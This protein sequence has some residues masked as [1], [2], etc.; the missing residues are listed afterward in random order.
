MRIAAISV[1]PIFPNYVIGGSQRILADVTA[2]LKNSGHD[3]QIWCTGTDSH[4]GDFEVGGVTV[5]PDL[6]L[7]G[8][9]PATHQVSPVALARTAETLRNAAEWADRVYLHADAVYLRHALEGTEIIRSIHDYVYEEALLSTLTLPAGTTVVPSEYLKQCIEATVAISGKKTIERVVVIPNGV[10]VPETAPIPILPDGI[11][12]RGEQDLILLFPH[13]PIPT[14]GLDEAIRTAVEVQ[15]IEPARNVRLLIPAY[16]SDA[17]FD[18]AAG[19]TDEL[20]ELVN[21]LDAVDIVEFHSWL[22]PTEMPGYYAGGD[23]ALCIGSFVESF[24]LVPVES[25]AN[26]TPA[27]CAR[28]GAFRQFANL[29]GITLVPYGQIDASTQAVLS[30]AGR[31][32]DLIESGRS[33][34]SHDYSP[35]SMNQGYESVISRALP[36][37]RKIE[38]L[39][40]DQLS[41]APWCDIQGEEIYDDYTAT[42]LQYPQLVSALKANAELV[43]SDPLL[44]SASLDAE[45]RHAKE[46]G[47]LIPN[48]VID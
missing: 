39:A 28:V 46:R 31:M 48:Y 25:V 7:R 38:L 14:K 42:R 24:G 4:N 5:H 10:Q 29:D 44:I 43:R 23:V 16:P 36:D 22:S 6:Q 40:D 17:N 21:D 11:S 18:D 15:K 13:R 30:A 26:G 2:G 8:S 45:V 33:Q 41:L 35:E 27:V 12:P 37:K 32:E 47:I 34:I 19:S 20:L 3:L 1:A 9:F